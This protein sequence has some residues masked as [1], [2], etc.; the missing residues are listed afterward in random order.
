V[1]SAMKSRLGAEYRRRVHPALRARI[2]RW[3]NPPPPRQEQ[4]VTVL[5]ITGHGRLDQLG[6]CLDSVVRSSY[7]NIEILVISDRASRSVATVVRSYARWDPRAKVVEIPAGLPATSSSISPE[8]QYLLV[9]E[10]PDR[11]EKGAVARLAKV[12]RLTE[13]DFARGL[14]ADQIQ[15]AGSVDSDPSPHGTD[16]LGLTLATDEV[17]PVPDRMSGTLFRSDFLADLGW[18]VEAAGTLDQ[19]QLMDRAYRSGRFDLVRRS[20]VWQPDGKTAQAGPPLRATRITAT[21]AER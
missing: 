3:R 19:Q 2:R 5:V 4:R 12:L 14:D 7:R 11:L 21:S 13:S 1:I 15:H 17:H 18:T 20:G 6:P 16:R 8:G 10:A 9:L